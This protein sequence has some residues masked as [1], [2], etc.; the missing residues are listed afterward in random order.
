M[1]APTASSWS[2]STN[3]LINFEALNQ[4]KYTYRDTKRRAPQNLYT[5]SAL[6]RQFAADKKV[7]S[8][9]DASVGFLYTAPAPVSKPQA[10]SLAYYFLDRGSAAGFVYSTKQNVY[11][12]SVRGRAHLDR[13]TGAQLWVNNVVVMQVSEAKRSGDDKGRIDQEVIGS[14]GARFFMDGK[15]LK[16]SWSKASAAAPLYFFDANGNEVVFSSGSVWIAAIPSFDRL[17]VK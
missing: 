7:S 6:L 13:I 10:T 3:Q 8:F 5:T 15:F 17:T 4:P 1:A 14:G 9:S 16:G 2:S 12:R 11:Y